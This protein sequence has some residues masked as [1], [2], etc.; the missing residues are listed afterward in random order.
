MTGYSDLEL[1]ELCEKQYR[2]ANDF[3]FAE[4]GYFLQVE[5]TAKEKLLR[6]KKEKMNSLPE[7]TKRKV[8]KWRFK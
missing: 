2:M 8:G 5:E 3:C 7:K 6:K 1:Q 4:N